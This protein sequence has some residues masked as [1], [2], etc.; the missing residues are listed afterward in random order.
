MTQ[1]TTAAEALS[2][3]TGLAVTDSPAKD[4]MTSRSKT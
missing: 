3:V 4:A 1:V 2:A